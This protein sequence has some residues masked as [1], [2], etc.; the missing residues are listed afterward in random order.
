MV[1]WGLAG[2]IAA[3]VAVLGGVVLVNL[4]RREERNPCSQAHRV[5]ELAENTMDKMCKTG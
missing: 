1:E 5:P 4:P 2:N 3:F